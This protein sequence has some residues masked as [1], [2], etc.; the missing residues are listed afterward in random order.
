[1]PLETTL[2]STNRPAIKPM[3]GGNSFNLTFLQDVA[4][5]SIENDRNTSTGPSITSQV[6]PLPNGSLGPIPELSGL[7][8]LPSPGINPIGCKII[9]NKHNITKAIAFN[10]TR[11][12]D[13]IPVTRSN[14]K[15]NNP[16]KI[17]I[18]KNSGY[19]LVRNNSFFRI[20]SLLFPRQSRFPRT[21]RVTSL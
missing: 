21:Q 10:P 5:G 20:F 15:R 4:F 9:K 19:R 16:T 11:P 12:Y 7:S 8:P 13:V 6:E 17:T 3:R 1:M 14:L 2:A 18:R